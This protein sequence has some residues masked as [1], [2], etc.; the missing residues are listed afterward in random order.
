MYEKAPTAERQQGLALFIHC[1]IY[2]FFYFLQGEHSTIYNL[3]WRE[4][5]SK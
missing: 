2:Q 5:H 4:S 1:F 3:L